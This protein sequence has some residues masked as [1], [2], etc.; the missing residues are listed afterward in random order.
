METSTQWRIDSLPN[1][2]AHSIEWRSILDVGVD[3]EE[4][5]TSLREYFGALWMLFLTGPAIQKPRH[6]LLPF[7]PLFIA[8]HFYSHE[9]C[10]WFCTNFSSL[11]GL[12]GFPNEICTS[13]LV[14]L[15]ALKVFI[16]HTLRGGR[17][18]SQPVYMCECL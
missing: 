2:S 10:G 11:C 1:A 14:G 18:I 8:L 7:S 5:F 3:F 15:A 9:I 17:G 4:L 16:C 6:P 12:Q 13:C